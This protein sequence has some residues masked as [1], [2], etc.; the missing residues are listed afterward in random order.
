MRTGRETA[1]PDEVL[2]A[3]EHVLGTRVGHVKVI[4]HSWFARLHARAVATTRP[5][6][7]YLRDDAADFFANP[8][9]MLHEYCHVVRQWQPGRLTV[10]RYLLECLRHG[11]WNNRFEVE[12]REFADLNVA[13]LRAMLTLLAPPAP[14]DS[15]A[16]QPNSA[17]RR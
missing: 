14:P 5:R 16:P 4:E 9:L 13:R 7:I 8:W 6:R 17:S 15:A 3:L 10:R 1:V 11:Y 12:A 2:A